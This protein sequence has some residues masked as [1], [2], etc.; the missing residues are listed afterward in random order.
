MPACCSNL[1]ELLVP[2]FFKALG[3]PT[4]V[5]VLANLAQGGCACTVSQVA[6]C[7]PVDLSVVSRHLHVLRD[8]GIVTARR[9]GKEVHYQVSYG[10]LVRTLRQI[11]DA[12]E[13]CCPEDAKG[14][15]CV[16]Q[17]GA[18]PKY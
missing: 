10:A 17:P 8:A 13:S 5:A 1:S 4:R 11:A 3:D 15:T 12:L 2:R 6:E 7:L 14:G 18:D 16:C 9:I